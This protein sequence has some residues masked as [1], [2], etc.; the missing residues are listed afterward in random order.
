MRPTHAGFF[1]VTAR[2]IAEEHIFRDERDYHAGVQIIAELVAAK[3]FECCGF[4]LMPTHYHVLGWFREG[5]LSNAIHRLNRRYASGFN[6]RHR[7]RGH[8]FDSPF[9]SVEVVTEQHGFH[10][11]DYIAENPPRR[12][13]PWSSYDAF[14]SF[15]RPLPW[16][17][18]REPGSGL[19]ITSA[20]LSDAAPQRE[21]REP[22]SNTEPGSAH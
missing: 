2:S 19:R 17:E 10:L 16:L 13:W 11:P 12:P 18:A 9:T 4:C 7:R 15:V 20:A 1:H 5:M 3:F 22:G 14:F 6:R 21:T 8:V